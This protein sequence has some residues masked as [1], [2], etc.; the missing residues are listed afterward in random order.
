V[1]RLPVEAQPQAVATT[2]ADER[3]MAEPEA[4][5]AA[6]AEQAASGHNGAVAPGADAEAQASRL[7]R[8]PSCVGLGILDHGVPLS[9][10]PTTVQPLQL[11]PHEG[12]RPGHHD[13]QLEAQAD[14]SEEQAETQPGDTYPGPSAHGIE[15]EDAVGDS[16]YEQPKARLLC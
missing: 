9:P 11:S 13:V 10:A 7:D 2:Q 1:Q 3:A 12:D 6:A 15:D 4:E 16:Q 8:P 14:K 5:A